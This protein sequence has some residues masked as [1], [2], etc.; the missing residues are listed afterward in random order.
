MVG[1]RCDALLFTLK[2][3]F[4]A[5]PAWLEMYMVDANEV[6]LEALRAPIGPRA[7][8]DTALLIAHLDDDT[9]YSPKTA[10]ASMYPPKT[11]NEQYKVMRGRLYA[12]AS[13]HQLRHCRDGELNGIPAWYGRTWKQIL[14]VYE[15]TRG[16]LIFDLL[17]VLSEQLE[18]RRAAGEPP[19][20]PGKY[21]PVHI[22]PPPPPPSRLAARWLWLAAAAGLVLVSGLGWGLRSHGAKPV[23]VVAR[24]GGPSPTMPGIGSNAG[25]GLGGDGPSYPRKI[26]GDESRFLLPGLD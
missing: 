26:F 6:V 16:R 15:M 21:L 9:L 23:A 24:G 22:K 3:L 25:D 20:P 1:P 2:A 19:L 12:F 18:Q 5:V 17:L 7:K 11:E 8:L 13:S 4:E 10:A 14:G